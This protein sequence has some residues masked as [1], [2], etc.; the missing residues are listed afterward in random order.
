M[1]D[2][3]FMQSFGTVAA[4]GFVTAVVSAILYFMA[5]PIFGGTATAW[6]FFYG[7]IAAAIGV[8]ALILRSIWDQR[9]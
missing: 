9:Q 7:L 3:R 8:L 2:L 6:I 5:L 4:I 1:T